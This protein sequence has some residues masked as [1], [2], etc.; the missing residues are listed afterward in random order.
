MITQTKSAQE[1]YNEI[2]AY[3]QRGSGLYRNWYVGIASHP[4][5]RLFNDHNVNEINDL[6]IYS[7]AGSE[8]NARKIEQFIIEQHGTDGGTGGGGYNTRY[9]YAYKKTAYTR[10]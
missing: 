8:E 9:V 7:D 3:I 6:W 4:K 10:P 5:D 1:I 2:I